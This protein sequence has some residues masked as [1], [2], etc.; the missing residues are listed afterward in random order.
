MTLTRGPD[1]ASAS[2]GA[3]SARAAASTPSRLA[4][5]ERHLVGAGAPR[6]VAVVGLVD[7]VDV[8]RVAPARQAPGQQVAPPRGVSDTEPLAARPAAARAAEALEAAREVPAVPADAPLQTQLDH[9][10]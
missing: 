7:R 8:E 5:T 2:A 10:D 6:V 9:E 1:A 3:A 4:D